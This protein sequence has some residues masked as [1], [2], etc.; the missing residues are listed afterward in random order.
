MDWFLYGRDLRH[1][2][3]LETFPMEVCFLTTEIKYSK[4]FL[5]RNSY[6]NYFHNLTFCVYTFFVSVIFF[7]WFIFFLRHFHLV[8]ML[9]TIDIKNL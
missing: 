5:S 4:S 8:C 6:S 3:V 2:R 7:L 9:K 1:E